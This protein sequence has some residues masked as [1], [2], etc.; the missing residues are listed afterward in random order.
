MARMARIDLV[1]LEIRI[2]WTARI[3]Y[4]TA[5]T[6]PDLRVRIGWTA[7]MKLLAGDF[8]DEAGLAQLVAVAASLADVLVEAVAAAAVEAA[9]AAPEEAVA[10]AEDDVVAA[11]VADVV[12]EEAEMPAGQPFAEHGR[13]W[14]SCEARGG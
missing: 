10:A 2:V 4:W 7:R 11:A 9:A 8:Q 3:G 6:G 12:A 13:T 1:G 14:A 5:L